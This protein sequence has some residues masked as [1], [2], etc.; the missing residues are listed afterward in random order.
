VAKLLFP[1]LRG[2]Q[3]RFKVLVSVSCDTFCYHWYVRS[4]FK[5]NAMR[6]PKNV[7]PTL[8]EIIDYW[9]EQ[10]RKNTGRMNIEHYMK[11]CHAKAYTLRW[12]DNTKT[13]SRV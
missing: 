7:K 12:N 1:E 2:T 10:K 6:E 4:N 5:I 8:I 9:L 3:R 11:V 13:W